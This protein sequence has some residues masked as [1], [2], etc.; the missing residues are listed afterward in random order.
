MN[1]E[2]NNVVYISFYVVHIGYPLLCTHYERP[3]D[4]H[5]I[6]VLDDGR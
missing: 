5:D 1:P 4:R 6:A 3:V 2:R